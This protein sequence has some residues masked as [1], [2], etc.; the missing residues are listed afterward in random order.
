MHEPASPARHVRF[1]AFELNIGS[2]EL[3]KG[4]TR[5]RVPDQS[6]EI[7]KALLEHPGELVTREA[8]RDRLWSSDTF[9]D[10][11]HGL[12]AAVRRLREALGDSADV[13]K[14]IE[15]LPRRGYRFIGTI[16]GEVVSAVAVRGQAGAAGTLTLE[17]VVSNPVDDGRKWKRTAVVVASVA[18]ALF[19]AAVAFLP[20]RPRIDPAN[21][22]PVPDPTRLTFDPGFQ[23][24]PTFS[25]DGRSIAYTSNKSGNFDIWQQP[26]AGG[27]AV[28]V[29]TDPAQDWQPDWSP[30]GSRIAFRSERGGG[31]IF[32]VPTTGGYEQ[33]I[34]EFGYRPRWSPDGSRILFRTRWF[35]RAGLLYL[36]GS[37]GGTTRPF[38]IPDAY[39]EKTLNSVDLEGA[40]GWHPDGRVSL[41]DQPTGVV[42]LFTFNADDGATS[43]FSV[44]EAVQ[45]R[46]REL[47]LTIASGEDMAWA[48]DGT[49]LYFV[50]ISKSCTK[51]VDAHRRSK[52]VGHHRR[53][54]SSDDRYRTD[55]RHRS[56]ERRPQDRLCGLHTQRARVAVCARCLR[57]ADCGRS[58]GSDTCRDARQHCGSNPRWH[59]AAL[60]GNP[61]R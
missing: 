20:L 48:P 52:V 13:P 15:T 36:V 61:S 45:K 40:D 37:K 5:L 28:P 39:S 6:I 49:G 7:L 46:F 19:L 55:Q 30:D 35:D 27:N 26:L 8:L 3:Y 10:F 29:T 11:E 22:L 60:P 57:Q 34:T 54:S 24:E 53:T 18:G 38:H 23:T 2:G 47:Q 42:R 16:D 32:V 17:P 1:G 25:H 14:Y 58:P 50:G 43:R 44:D 59:E 51:R 4:R 31:G 9:V 12:N 21:A 56:V 41:L 33:R